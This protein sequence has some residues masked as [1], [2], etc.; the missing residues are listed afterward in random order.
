MRGIIYCI[1]QK[2]TGYDSPIYIGSTKDFNMRKGT[3]KYNCNNPNR[4]C[5]NIKLY[6]YIREN[7]GWDNFE[8]LEI[9]AVDYE[10]EEELRVEEQKWIEDLGA[11]L[12]NDK[13]YRSKEDRKEYVFGKNI[14]YREKYK[15]YYKKHNNEKIKCECGF[16]GIKKNMTRHRKSKKH[17]KNIL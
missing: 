11:T 17:I 12:N 9:G 2:E 16:I 14:E 15:E 13:A 8:I 3:H 1:K 7:D 5:Y 10:T 6:K 4:K